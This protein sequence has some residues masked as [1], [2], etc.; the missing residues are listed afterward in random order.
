MKDRTAA[1]EKNNI[2]VLNF[3]GRAPRV[4]DD[5]YRHGVEPIERYADTVMTAITKHFGNDLPEIIIEPGRSLVGDAGVIQSEVVLISQKSFG[6]EKRWVYLDIGKFNGLAETTDEMI[7]YPIRTPFDGD[8]MEPC[9]IAGPS[10]DSQSTGPSAKPALQLVPLSPRA[11]S[12]KLS[13]DNHL[14]APTR[15]NAAEG[16]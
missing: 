9:V 2:A 14:T 1:V 15:A 6:D 12:S 13:H 5:R 3:G 16:R 7:R 8:A 10:C 4:I 11:Y